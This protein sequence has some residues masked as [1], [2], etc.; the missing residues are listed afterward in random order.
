MTKRKES[1]NKSK[2]YGHV[3]GT[4]HKLS[5]GRVAWPH[6]VEAK[7]N[8]FPVEEGQE[9]PAPRF[10]VTYLSP[11]DDPELE[12][13]KKEAQEMVDLYNFDEKTG[14]PKKNK[15]VVDLDELFDDGDSKDTDKYPFFADSYVIVPKHRERPEIYDSQLNLLD[16]SQVE[17]GMPVVLVIK[18]ICTS[19]G[20]SF[21][22]LVV[23]A[24]VDDGTRFG[25]SA[26]AAKG[27]LEVLGSAAP[28][29]A[30][31][32]DSAPFDEDEVE[33]EE[34][35]DSEE[36]DITSAPVKVAPVVAA[37]KKASAKGTL[38]LDKLA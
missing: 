6:L 29:P 2:K 25:G 30:A 10:E 35:E 24:G 3:Y 38:N 26:P 28:A 17:G 7:E 31:S 18:P 4:Q 32:K 19:H 20:I 1:I 15:L 12:L 33:D 9:K 14:K 11:K 27:L 16:P 8:T 5:G 23:Q 21:Q 36:E 13:I 34:S 22:L 37:K